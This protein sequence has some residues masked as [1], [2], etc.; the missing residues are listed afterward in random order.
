MKINEY[1]ELI[2]VYEINNTIVIIMI[3]YGVTSYEKLT[4]I[5]YKYLTM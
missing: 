2:G 5:F 4:T 1:K 3:K